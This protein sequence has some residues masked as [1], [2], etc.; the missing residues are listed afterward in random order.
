LTHHGAL[1]HSLRPFLL[2]LALFYACWL[3]YVTLADRWSVVVEHW[4]IAAAMAL[5]SYFAGSTPMGG[6]TVGF[7]VL[8]LL[9]NEPASLGRD[10][11][12]AIQS[13]GMLSASIFIFC[14][15]IPLEW[16]I[17]KWALI[18]SAIGTPIGVF[19]VAPFIPA[20]GVKLVF[21]ITWASF[22]I[23]HFWKIGEIVS[24]EGESKMSARFY[25]WAGLGVGFLGGATAAA[26]TGVGVD[27][28]LYAILVLACRADLKIAIPT[29]V[30]L[31]AFTSLV[32]IATRAVQG[33]LSEELFGNWLAAAPVVV[34]GAPF[35]ALIASRIGRKPTLI[36]V[37]LLCVIQFVWTIQ[38]EWDVLQWT[39]SLASL[40]AVGVVLLLF[41]WL[42]HVG[43]A[44][45]S[46]KAACAKMESEKG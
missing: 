22:G 4:G 31:M 7:P 29:S 30:I 28:L 1:K 27:M 12:F 37:S 34:V 40:V 42:H 26:I 35:G 14:R 15:R 16:H 39:G 9:F 18:G 44:F 43:D 23:L 33:G 6:G 45:L 5:G 8:V 25:Q 2:W 24:A 10:F 32:G 20:L 17:L 41:V 19:L 3:L 11:S 36:V 21:A 13:A 38:R 46:K